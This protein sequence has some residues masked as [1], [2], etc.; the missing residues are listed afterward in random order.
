MGSD[1]TVVV[2]TRNRSSQI[3][4]T[5]ET[6]L[7]NDYP[8]FDILVI[9][10]SDNDLTRKALEPYLGIPRFRYFH[11]S[12]RGI[13]SGR[14]TGVER[15]GCELIAMTDDD[16]QVAPDW[17]RAIAQAFHADE[18]IAVVFGNVLAGPHDPKAGFIPAYTRAE[19][20][21][22]TSIFQKHRVEGIG[23]C[24]GIRRS[25]WRRMHGFDENLG[26][27]GRFCSAE[28]LDFAVRVLLGGYA[29]FETP[30]AQVVHNGFRTWASGNVL[31]R[32]YLYGIGAMFAKLLKLGHFSVLALMWCLAWR[33]AFQKPIVDLGRRPP[34]LLRIDAFARGFFSGLVFPVDR[35][36]GQY[37]AR[38]GYYPEEAAH[39]DG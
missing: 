3:V 13:A 14:N 23:A 27:G 37:M 2:P 15:A 16:C 1:I 10:Q 21:L 17:V 11:S 20:Y 39:S 19:P 18:R 8:G 34:R 33:W 24:M 30:N 38:N 26:A 7:A 29:V 32:T 35:R 36:K 31:I 12:K 9:D 22:A 28:D 25:A 4:R 6:I 5:L